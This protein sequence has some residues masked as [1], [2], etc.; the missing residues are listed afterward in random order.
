M[1]ILANDGFNRANETPLAAP[2]TAVTG[3]TGTLDLV[4][5]GVSA[6]NTNAD[7]EYYYSGVAFPAD[8]YA[9]ARFFV[10]VSANGNDAG[11]GLVVRASAAARTLYRL[12][13][14]HAAANNI[15]LGRWV[16]GVYT[17]IIR[18]TQAWVEGDTFELRAIGT[19]LQVFLN[20]VQL[21][22]DQIDANIT[23]GSAGIAYSSTVSGGPQILDDWEAGDIT[24]APIIIGSAQQPVVW[25]TRIRP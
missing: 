3:T 2:W 10:G 22:T 13:A 9:K 19:T 24:V 14:D 18:F 17:S 25:A 8:Q 16:A 11:Y 20:S 4:S 15:G 12:T 1:S 6:H 23:T 7:S 21:G 5:N